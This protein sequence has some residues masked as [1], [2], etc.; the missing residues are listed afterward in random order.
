MGRRLFFLYH[1]FFF[2]VHV[3][4]DFPGAVS[5][6]AAET[7]LGA[8]EWAGSGAQKLSWLLQGGIFAHWK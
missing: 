5:D 4:W 8:A 7:L 2:K 3:F 1:H 6:L